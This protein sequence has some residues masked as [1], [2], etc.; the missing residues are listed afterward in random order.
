M[1]QKNSFEQAS[2][3]AQVSRSVQEYLGMDDA[4][5]YRF[6]P[7]LMAFLDKAETDWQKDIDSQQGPPIHEPDPIYKEYPILNDAVVRSYDFIDEEHYKPLTKA[8]ELIQSSFNLPEPITREMDSPRTEVDGG[9]VSFHDNHYKLNHQEFDWREDPD[10]NDAVKRI[11]IRER[12]NK[13][14]AEIMEWSSDIFDKILFNLVKK[15]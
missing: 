2:Q 15:I 8:D 13:F 7:Y 11:E 5:F 14:R 4:T 6:E 9:S 1:N 12:V 3:Y 10:M